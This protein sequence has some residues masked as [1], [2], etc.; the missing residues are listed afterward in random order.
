M[1]VVAC[2]WHRFLVS[3]TDG[4]RAYQAIDMVDGK[5][6]N[7]GWVRGKQVQRCHQVREDPDG[8]YV[9]SL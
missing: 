6:V 1:T 2:P 4:C 9:V 5:P 3:V 8:I 7:K